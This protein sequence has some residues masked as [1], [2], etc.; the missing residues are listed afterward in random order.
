MRKSKSRQAIFL[1]TA[2]LGLILLGTDAA[3]ATSVSGRFGLWSYVRDDTV[4]HVQVVPLLSLNVNRI[5]NGDWSFEST[6]R[7]FADYQNGDANN[8]SAVRVNRALLIWKPQASK[9]EVRAGQQ[10]LTEGIGR[11]NVAGLW[12]AYKFNR[13]TDAH[14]YAGSRLASSLSLDEENPD[15][16]IA[17]GFNIRTKFGPRRLGLSYYYVGKDGDVLYNG[18]GLDYYCTSIR[19]LSMRA[20][21]HMNLEQSAIETG[22]I[23]ANWEAVD[24]LLITADVRTQTPRIFEDSFFAMFLE[25]SKTNS[26]RVGATWEF[27]E[28]TYVTG[29]AYT[30]FTELDQLYKVRAGIGDSGFE[31]GYTHW[32]SADKGDMDGFYGEARCDYKTL[33]GSFGFDYSR[34]SNSEVRPNTEDQV[35]FAGVEWSPLKSLTLGARGEHLKDPE[36]TEDW[37]AL[38]SLMTNFRSKVRSGS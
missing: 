19:D 17:A 26:A 25:D 18:V 2:S 13:K 37:R 32:L 27:E 5:G 3:Q 38:F 14:V 35:I 33:E 28:E 15:Q 4:D 16:G 24:D 8:T 21:L 10:W 9:W 22:Q 31:F 12:G 1:L 11:G 23:T 20:R 34:G 7:G 36:H 29:M 30:I 6:L